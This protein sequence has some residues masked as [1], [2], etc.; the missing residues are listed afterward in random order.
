LLNG[1]DRNR[2]VA[3]AAI[4]CLAA[5]PASEL[6]GRQANLGRPKARVRLPS[7]V[8]PNWTKRSLLVVTE[9]LAAPTPALRQKRPF[10]DPVPYLDSVVT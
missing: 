6:F 5:L 7:F 8:P 9:S 2:F 4:G 3:S 10:V 1:F